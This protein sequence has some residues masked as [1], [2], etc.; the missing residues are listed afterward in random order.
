MQLPDPNQEKID[1]L[2]KKLGLKCIGWIFT[3]LII[4]DAREGTVKNFRGN[5]DTYF[6]TAEEC[7][8]AGYFQN[9]YRNHTKYSTDGYFGSKFVTVV[10]TGIK[11]IAIN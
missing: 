11:Y 7:I 4:E 8:M 2:S 9:I 5:S 10:V 6:L 1:Y 3:D